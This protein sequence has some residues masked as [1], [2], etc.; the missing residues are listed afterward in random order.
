M[1][2][3]QFPDIVYANKAGELRR[4]KSGDGVSNGPLRSLNRS[5]FDN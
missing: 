2:R 5:N 3:L 4:F 1:P